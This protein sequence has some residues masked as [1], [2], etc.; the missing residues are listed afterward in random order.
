MG[1]RRV[2]S[3]LCLCNQ[4][5]GIVRVPCVCSL[6]HPPSCCFPKIGIVARLHFIGDAACWICRDN[7]VLEVDWCVDWTGIHISREDCLDTIIWMDG[8]CS[9]ALPLLSCLALALGLGVLAFS[10]TSFFVLCFDFEPGHYLLHL[11][12]CS[13][14]LRLR[15]LTDPFGLF[16]LRTTPGVSRVWFG[17]VIQ[18][19]LYYAILVFE[20]IL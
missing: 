17:R 2:W 3:C 5:F 18:F 12:I 13:V 1:C 7:R 11:L 9:S 16:H 14:A 10:I 15:A 6:T 19:I 4:E 8:W 20:S